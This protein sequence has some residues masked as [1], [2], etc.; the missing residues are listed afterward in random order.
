[1]IKITKKTDYGLTLLAALAKEP[2]KLFSLRA[3]SIE[4]KLPYKFI[5]QVAGQLLDAGIIVSKEGAA[6]GYKLA[7]NP[8]KITL[9]EVLETLDGPMVKIDC[10]KGKPCPREAC[11]NHQRLVRNVADVVAQSLTQKTLADL[12]EE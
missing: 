7:K 8:S 6:G 2:T 1:M 4:H 11:C 5:G 10:L 12:V 3:I 9:R